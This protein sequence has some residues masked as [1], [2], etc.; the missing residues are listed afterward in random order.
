M[1]KIGIR[2][3]LL[4][5]LL[6]VIFNGIRKIFSIIMIEIIDFHGSL[7]LT[8]LM[9]IADFISGLIVYLFNLK[10]MK[11][12][13][14]QNFKGIELIQAPLEISSPDNKLKIYFLLF[15]GSYLDF[16]E[17]VL[18]SYYIPNT[19]KNVSISLQW[20]IKSIIIIASSIFCFF[21]LKFPIYKHQIYSLI[22]IS[23][24][25]IILIILEFIFISSVLEVL[26]LILLSTIDE[27]FNSS[28]D[29]IEKYLLEYDFINPYEMLM[30]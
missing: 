17:Y 13:K 5:P 6:F 1:I 30:F 19:Y 7:I 29:V 22:I 14:Y 26:Q 21:S 27:I 23:I 28:L 11:K 25:L 4:Y 9:F 12:Q 10:Y 15:L 2:H 20:R 16:T 3:N 24:T 8:A 18:S